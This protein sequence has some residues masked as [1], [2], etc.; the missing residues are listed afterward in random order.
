MLVPGTAEFHVK[1]D[2]LIFIEKDSGDLYRIT[3]L[4]Q[5]KFSIKEE[6]GEKVLTNVADNYK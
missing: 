5:G 1:E 3:G 4:S 6:S 2:V